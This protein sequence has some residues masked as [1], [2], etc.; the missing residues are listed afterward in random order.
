MY[1]GLLFLEANSTGIITPKELDWVTKH[2]VSFT[3][4]EEAFA[5]KLGRLIDSGVI[6][7]GCRLST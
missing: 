3:R 5:I 4:V 6:N 2:Q 1:L 7:I